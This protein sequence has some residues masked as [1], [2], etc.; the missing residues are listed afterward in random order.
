MFTCLQIQSFKQF[1]CLQIKSFKQIRHFK[2]A[3]NDKQVSG[4]KLY[5]MQNWGSIFLRLQSYYYVYS[6]S[7]RNK[8]INKSV[9]L[10]YHGGKH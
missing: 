9:L 7:L 2:I 4:I 8:Q 1:T 6:P 3:N 10:L 5:K